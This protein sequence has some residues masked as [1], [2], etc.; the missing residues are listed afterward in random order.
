MIGTNLGSDGQGCPNG[1]K[2]K[3][4]RSL[5]C[6]EWGAPDPSTCKWYG[7][8]GQCYGQCQDDE[9][10]MLVDDFGGGKHCDSGLRKVWCC[11]MTQGDS[12]IKQCEVKDIGK[13]P[14]NKPQIASTFGEKKYDGKKDLCCPEKPK[15][16][17]CA[18]HGSASLCR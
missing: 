2:N 11:K 16:K 18:W 8:A 15:L 12:F 6:P 10:L 14:S 7:N 9:I 13:C 17:N 1:Y 4:Q 3:Q 5:C